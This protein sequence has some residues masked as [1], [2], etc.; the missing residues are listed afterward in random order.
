M[1]GMERA[2][3]RLLVG[4]RLSFLLLAVW[5]AAIVPVHMAEALGQDTVALTAAAHADDADCLHPTHGS[6]GNGGLCIGHA[7]CLV[8][9][10]S[11]AGPSPPL[12]VERAMTLLLETGLP[13]GRSLPPDRRPPKST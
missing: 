4:L 11:N 13:P 5:L 6:V 12:T 2:A 9:P 10:T 3:R 1:A 8:V 7:A